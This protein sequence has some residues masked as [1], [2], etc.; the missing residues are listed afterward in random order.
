[1]SVRHGVL[2]GG[3]WIVDKLKIID[4]YPQQ[5]ALSN[6]LNESVGN[7][8]SWKPPSRWRALAWSA[9]TPRAAGCVRFVRVM[10]ST[11]RA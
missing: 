5:D 3:N 6:I 9:T 7:G 8:G 11:P 1:M 4:R 2:A 10:A